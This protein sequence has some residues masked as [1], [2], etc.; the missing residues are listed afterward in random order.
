[1]GDPKWHEFMAPIL[2]CLLDG[3]TY[4]RREIYRLVAD[5]VQLTDEQLAETLNSGDSRYENRT[6]WAI[7]YLN[8]VGALERPSR[9]NYVITDVGR[10][11][12]KDQPHGITEKDLRELAGESTG[13]RSWYALLA[14]EQSSVEETQ[15]EPGLDPTEQIQT[16]IDRIHEDVAADLLSRLHANDPGFFE[17]TVV[18]LLV[19]MG[20]GG[21]SGK[22]TVTSQTNDGGIDGIIDQDTLGLNRIYVQAKRYSLESSVSRPD[23]QSFVGALSGKAD[24]GVF[25]TTARFSKGA[26]EYA[27]SIP[28]RIILI[29]GARLAE[30]MIKFGVGVEVSRTVKIVRVDE[31]FF[32]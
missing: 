21:T 28:T 23:I 8:R 22:A 29:D 12:L 18:D 6:G 31:D 32:E 24:G 16:G 10:E 11:L 17:Q 4:H 15:E 1:M 2:Q 14:K 19:A 27:Q 30:L 3:E 26:I 20:Y 5:R 9:G 7:S 13:S 25:I